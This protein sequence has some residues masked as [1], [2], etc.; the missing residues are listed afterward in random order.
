MGGLATGLIRA[1]FEIR[2]AN[3]IDKHASATF[4]HRF[5]EIRFIM[6]DVCGLSAQEHGLA[7]VDLLAGGFPCQSFSQAGDRKGFDDPRGR[8]FFQIPRLLDEMEPSVRPRLLVLENVPYLRYGNGGEWF[9]TVR[10]Q[11]RKSGYWFRESA[12]LT[13]NVKDYT[14]VPQDRERLFMIAASKAYFRHNPFSPS[15]VQKRSNAKLR[16]LCEYVNRSQRALDEA[17]LPKEN[18]YYKMIREK[19]KFSDSEDNIFQLRRSYVR[20]KKLGLCPTL[21]ANMGVGG[22]NVPFVKDKWG[23]RRLSVDEVASLQGFE[24]NP[25]L[26]PDTLPEAERYRLIG[27]ATCVHL[28]SLVGNACHGILQGLAS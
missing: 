9:D 21:T 18:R 25:S 1:G 11:L 24:T 3:D 28:A 14:A 12:C 4:R 15:L 2:W 7:D 6:E 20:E 27:N 19:M 16:P 10:H 8:L 22:H 13:A 17:Y 23:I 26:F 5:P